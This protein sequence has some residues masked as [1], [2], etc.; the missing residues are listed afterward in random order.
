M[1]ALGSPIP[2]ERSVQIA[3]TIRKQIPAI[4]LMSMGANKFNWIKN[5]E[6]YE[7]VFL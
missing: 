5:S 7:V 6:K 4:C 2:K 1:S 3:D